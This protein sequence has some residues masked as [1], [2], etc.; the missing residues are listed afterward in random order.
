MS[1]LPTSAWLDQLHHAT[2]EAGCV[3]G[4]GGARRRALHLPAYQRLNLALIT[5]SGALLAVHAYDI[6]QVWPAVTRIPLPADT[7]SNPK[8]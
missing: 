4:Q 2:V 3:A 7:P 8:S 1:V 6:A 5:F